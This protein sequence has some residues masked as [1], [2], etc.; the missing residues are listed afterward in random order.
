MQLINAILATM[1]ITA[2]IAQPLEQ[3]GRNCSSICTSYSTTITKT[4]T[5]NEKR[6][7]Q[8]DTR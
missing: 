7:V 2:V 3:A 4:K 6:L 8:S 1:A 5:I